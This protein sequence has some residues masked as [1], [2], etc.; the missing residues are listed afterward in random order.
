MVRQ[1]IFN[2][3][4]KMKKV[5]LAIYSS[6]FFI[7]QNTGWYT[8]ASS[9]G[10]G[11]EQTTDCG[12][13]WFAALNT[14]R[15]PLY[16]IYFVNPLTGWAVGESGTI[17]KSMNNNYSPNTNIKEENILNN[18]S[19]SQNYPNPFNPTTN[20]QFSIPNVQFVTLKV[21]DILGKEVATLVNEKLNAG[22]YEATFN[23]RNIQAE[24][25]FID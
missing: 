3:R 24:F 19:L 25:I 21:F 2:R 18:Y 14:I 8:V 10:N 5:P 17:Y 16:S 6:V 11:I 23:A 1:F 12:L 4:K 9:L 13:T 22:T 7:N 15:T 20:V